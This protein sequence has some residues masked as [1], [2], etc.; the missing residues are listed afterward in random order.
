MGLATLKRNVKPV[1]GSIETAGAVVQ[2]AR[3]AGANMD[4]EYG[5]G[6]GIIER[7]LG[8]HALGPAGLANRQAF[9]G[10][11]KDQDH[12]A[13]DLV[14]HAGKDGGST[15]QHGDMG[16]MAAGMHDMHRRALIFAHGLG[17][18]GKAGLFL[19]RQGIHISA[20]GDHAAGLATLQHGNNAGHR[21]LGAD[22][23]PQTFQLSGDQGS[24]ANLAIAQFGV[25]M[26]IAPPDHDLGLDRLGR[27]KH[28]LGWHLCKGGTGTGQAKGGGHGGGQ[29]A[30]ARFLER[31]LVL[32]L[33]RAR[34]RVKVIKTHGFPQGQA[35]PWP[36]PA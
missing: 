21:H 6:G 31:G 10:G 34:C 29:E 19:N 16:V 27:G 15:Q 13:R 35:F 26:K 18:E 23:K 9:F 30:H 14:A 20:Q 36:E 32:R 1:G 5:A 3:I 12:G 22:L 7:A 8:D 4:A 11:L 17:G 28:G 25:F 2:L 24:R 33:R